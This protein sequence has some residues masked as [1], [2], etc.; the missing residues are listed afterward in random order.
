MKKQ[1]V[2][3][4]VFFTMNANLQ[5]QKLTSIEKKAF[6][7]LSKNVTKENLVY[8]A[9]CLDIDLASASIPIIIEK[10]IQTSNSNDLAQKFYTNEKQFYIY[11][12]GITNPS[13]LLMDYKNNESIL[14]KIELEKL[15]EI[16]KN[17]PLYH[18]NS[19]EE[20]K[21]K[22]YKYLVWS[23]KQILLKNN[24]SI[25]EKIETQ[26]KEDCKFMIDSGK[27]TPAIQQKY[28]PLISARNSDKV[29]FLNPAIYSPIAKLL[30]FNDEY[31]LVNSYPSMNV[32][33]N[34]CDCDTVFSNPSTDAK[35]IDGYYALSNLIYKNLKYPLAEAKA[36][37]SGDVIIKIYINMDGK[38]CATEIE[39]S[40]SSLL[41]NEAMRVFSLLN[42]FIP[43]KN[44]GRNV[45]SSY[46]IPVHFVLPK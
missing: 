32:E 23:N 15:Y 25:D 10:I 46:A 40:V 21:L 33:L 45:C 44:N 20:I 18:S 12:E 38:I 24:L 37:I 31:V 43:A 11:E 39:K 42:D 30:N 9:Y 29:L 28:Y 35:Y 17:A 34:K 19:L 4:L 27:I 3:Y 16:I 26:L 8:L 2:F 41:D 7:N 13:I 36:E 5:A 22:V 14:T 1:I 6:L